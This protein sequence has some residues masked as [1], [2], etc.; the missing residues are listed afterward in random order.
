MISEKHSIICDAIANIMLHITFA[1]VKIYNL[2]AVRFNT[3][4]TY[5]TGLLQMNELMKQVRGWLEI[6]YKCKRG[7]GHL[8][9]NAW[10][11]NLY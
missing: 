10:E 1:I 7:L 2:T 5:K 9:K 3:Y 6:F 4:M 11:S 8:S